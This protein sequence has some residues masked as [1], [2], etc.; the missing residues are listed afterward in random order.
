MKI[1]VVVP[2][3]SEQAIARDSINTILSYTKKIPALVTLLIVNDASNDDTKAIVEETVEQINDNDRLKMISHTENQG[4]GTANRTGVKFAEEYNYDYVL[5]MDCDLTDHPK[6][7]KAFYEKMKDGWDYIKATRYS[8]EGGVEGVPWSHRIISIIGNRV[9]GFLFGLPLSDF[10]NGFRAVKTDILKQI[11]F[12]E[13]G[14]VIIMEELY[15]AKFL[16]DSFCEISHI[17]TSRKMDQGQTHFSY[18]P[19]ACMRYL[20]YAVKSFLRRH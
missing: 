17:L 11:D 18:G 9:A 13:K 14:F 15:R 4:Y 3:Y 12:T 8:K 10:T 7:I 16:T 5:F 19:S 1:C 2:M 20:K 6:Y